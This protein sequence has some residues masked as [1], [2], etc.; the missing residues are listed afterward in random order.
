MKERFCFLPF[1]FAGTAAGGGTITYVMPEAATFHS[2]AVWTNAVA[3]GTVTVRSQATG[4]GTATLYTNSA[5]AGSAYLG[6]AATGAGISLKI[7]KDGTCLISGTATSETQ[8][9]GYAAF[10]IGE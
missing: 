6:T 8:M 10:L 1:I 7:P 5:K 3:G 2:G 4:Q 9:S